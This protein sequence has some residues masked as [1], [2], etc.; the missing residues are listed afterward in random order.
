MVFM[1]YNNIKVKVEKKLQNKE[2]KLLRIEPCHFI[3]K[4]LFV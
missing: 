3:F 2:K 4:K 1:A